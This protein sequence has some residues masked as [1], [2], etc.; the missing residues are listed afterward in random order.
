[1]KAFH[2]VLDSLA[3]SRGECNGRMSPFREGHG[4]W[5]FGVSVSVDHSSVQVQW[6]PPCSVQ[7][8][9]KVMIWG[10]HHIYRSWILR[11]LVG[12]IWI[13]NALPRCLAYMDVSDFTSTSKGDAHC[14]GAN[15]VPITHIC[16]GT[17][18]CSLV[19][20][21]KFMEFFLLLFLIFGTF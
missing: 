1:M 12:V 21:L 18:G 4:N 17:S 5:M 13:R 2:N 9:T 15:F 10:A 16:G 3:I 6:W 14:L 11:E 19:V 7:G 20:I 8:T